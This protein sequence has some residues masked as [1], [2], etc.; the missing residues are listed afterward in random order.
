VCVYLPTNNLSSQDL[1]RETLAELC[2]FLDSHSFDNLVIAGDFN[3]DFSKSS[4]IHH[5]L[6]SDF[7]ENLD[8]HSVDLDFAHHIKFTYE[9]DDRLRRS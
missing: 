7:I 2:G 8:L 6:L 3:V 9:S 4:S 5:A 1:Y